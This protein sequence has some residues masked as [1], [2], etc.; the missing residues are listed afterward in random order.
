MK[1]SHHPG[2]IGGDLAGGFT[3][4]V[5]SLPMNIM[6]GI[7]AF[8][9]LG[10][11]YAGMGILAGM[12]SSVFV[13]IFASLFGGTPGM[14][15]GPKATTSLIFASVL[16]Y[17]MSGSMAGQPALSQPGLLLYLG[18]LLILFSGVFQALFGLFRLG[19]LIKY[20]PYPVIAGFLNGTAIVVILGQSWNFFGI[21]KGENLFD[22]F[23]NIR[24]FQPLTFLVAFITIL[25]ILLLHRKFRNLP[26]S[27]FGLLV[28]TLVYYALIALGLG[29]ELGSTIGKIN[30]AAPS[31]YL[32]KNWE[33][34]AQLHLSLV[35]S[36][37]LP[38]AFS[39]ALLNSIDS[40]L[41]SLAIQNLTNID[42][43][44]N[45]D[46]LGQG[47]GNIV[48][49]CFGGIAGSGYVGRSSLNYWA[50]G[51][52]NLSSVFYSLT[53]LFFVLFLFPVVGYIPKA[54]IAAILIMMAFQIF[55]KWSLE[56]YYKVLFRKI[57]RK[58]ELF[59]N[60]VIISLVMLVTVFMNLVI[61]VLLGIVLAIFMFVIKMSKRVIR[62]SYS[63]ATIHS[64]TK[65]D[66]KYADVLQRYG[67]RIRVLELEGVIFFGSADQFSQEVLHQS[68]E[69]VAYIILDMKRVDEI[70]STGA[71]ILLQT[72]QRLRNLGKSLAISYIDKERHLWRFLEDFGLMAE[73]S[74]ELFFPDTDAA[75]ESFENR[76]L[77][78]ILEEPFYDKEIA[79]EDFSL[80]EGLGRRDL[81]TV[82]KLFVKEEFP[83]GEIV[84]RQGDR[85]D[86]LF[87]IAKG[88][89]DVTLE[90]P[91]IERKKRLHSLAAGTFFG[92]MALLDGR[93]RSANVEAREKLVCY[94]LRLTDFEKLKKDRASLA[95]ILLANVSRTIASR[96]RFANE[97]I[98]ELEV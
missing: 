60:F 38:A 3:A 34:G 9:P 10:E 50:G 17:M 62:R 85:G 29:D 23:H 35:M 32:L 26:G 11:S 55:D 41:A 80:F 97:M 88:L 1:K 40:M 70:D 16:A 90:L 36:N 71:R 25:I 45:R 89:A 63:G 72:Y 54:V 58:R 48:S 69:E 67:H 65:R 91:G 43:R 24:Y 64:K 28:G 96:L 33:L 13:G 21:P 44:T 22:F 77:E 76:L 83:C 18:F 6:F 15:S 66:E 93:P 4:A 81:R 31:L 98:S 75:L 37:L 47:I 74:P 42:S 39:I 73:L 61:A 95:M 5:I 52:T 8:A 59:A 94:R 27:I 14:I 79:L 46:L 87:L 57:G 92:E 86:A 19:N 53:I 12:Y 7:V 68:Q 82:K 2:N 51:R 49:A 56:L 30:F 84:F 20:I 78:K